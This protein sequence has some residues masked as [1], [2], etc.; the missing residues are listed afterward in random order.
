[1]NDNVEINIFD[2]CL[3]EEY[4]KSKELIHHNP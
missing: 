4:H 3:K 1:M 2:N